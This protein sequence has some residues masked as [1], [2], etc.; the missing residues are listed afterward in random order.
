[1]KKICK[2]FS[3]F[4]I[5]FSYLLISS[6]SVNADD[7]V[8]S[9]VL[10]DLNKDESFDINNYPAKNY[11]DLKQSNCYEFEVITISEG[12]NK[13][14]FI[15]VYNPTRRQL[16]M[17]AIEVSMYCDF[18]KNPKEFHPQLFSLKLVS[19]Y[20]VF[21]KYLVEDFIVS[22]E[23]DRYYNIIEISRSFNQL[24]DT[25][26]DNGVTND[27]AIP[28]GKQFY[29]YYYNDELIVESGTFKTLELEIILNGF[30]TY[31][32][33]FT[34]GSLINWKNTSCRSHFVAFNCENYII[35]KIYDA[36]LIYDMVK[37][38]KRDYKPDSGESG[39]KVT[40]LEQK[41]DVKKTL[42]SSD[43]TV[44]FDGKGLNAKTY[45]WNRI[46]SSY[47]Y[48]DNFEKQKG[49]FDES[50]LS[51][52]Q[53]AQWVFSFHETDYTFTEFKM[54]GE[55]FFDEYIYSIAENL[56]ILRISFLDINDKYYNLGVVVD[57]TTSDNIEDG[58]ADPKDEIK[59]LLKKIFSAILFVIAFLLIYP[60]ISPVIN[61]FISLIINIIK[62]LFKLIIN[63]LL[64]PFRLIFK[65]KEKKPN[66]RL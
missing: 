60:F 16:N 20:D 52:L 34:L 4:I 5:M 1:M 59:D 62:K 35:K 32:N 42:S 30:V 11:E 7:I 37:Y 10:D 9:N 49:S 55:Y 38:Q 14:L 47:E 6:I 26:I 13:E 65:K 12:I 21:D 54:N 45:K 19:K 66:N 17:N 64:F 3:I 44:T 33:G 24:I 41:L 43:D 61:V 53:Q 51:K 63:V 25:S 18:A 23:S 31:E 48:I 8:Y 29:F 39:S 57:K 2:I 27:K 40:V 36:D 28:V 58:N 22:D 15:Y 56:D 50:S 46:M